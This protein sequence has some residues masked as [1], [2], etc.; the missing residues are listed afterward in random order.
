MPRFV[1]ES[2]TKTIQADWWSEKETCT[3]RKFNYGDRQYLAG[4]TVYVGLVPKD[5]SDGS[6]DKEDIEGEGSILIDRMNLAILER[7]IKS[8]TDEE[9]SPIPVTLKMIES[10]TEKDAD[11]ILSK[12]N[13]M[14]PRRQRTEEEQ[15][16][17]RESSGRRAVAE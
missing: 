15:E 4:Q 2:Q 12:I 9:G 17:F 1:D 11:F 13:E 3:I 10:L 16:T 8:W 5:G 6:F 14:N 7:G